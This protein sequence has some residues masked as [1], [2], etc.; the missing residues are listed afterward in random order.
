MLA[1]SKS[2]SSL[3][4]LYIV[5]ARFLVYTIEAATGEGFFKWLQ[6]L[7]AD[8]VTLNFPK[9]LPWSFLCSIEWLLPPSCSWYSPGET[10]AARIKPSLSAWAIR[11]LR[12]SSSFMLTIFGGPFRGRRQL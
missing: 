1:K 3:D 4:L 12:N 7:L 11:P 8:R 2:A 6:N 9:T 5:G 10:R